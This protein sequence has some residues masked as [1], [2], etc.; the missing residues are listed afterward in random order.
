[1]VGSAGATMTLGWSGQ[2][3]TAL[4]WRP[5]ARSRPKWTARAPRRLAWRVFTARG[6]RRLALRAM[7]GGGPRG[8]GRRHG[9]PGGRH[10]FGGPPFGGGPFFAGF[11]NFPFGRGGPR[12]RRGD[13]RVAI[14]MLLAE[15]PRNGYQLMQEIESRSDGVWRPSPGSI[16]PALSQLEDEGLVLG[17]EGV[18]GSGKVFALTD[19]GRAYVA[20][21]DAD[22]P[23]P[24]DTVGDSM[25]DGL[26]D[27]RTLIG[28]VA[29][30]AMQVAH[31]G[32]EEQ[33]ARAAQTLADTRRALYRLL[34][35][36]EG[37]TQEGA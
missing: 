31:A 15:E 34:A 5:G 25:S 9:G 6:R 22:E 29:G 26:H 10:G 11:G 7:T 4:E 14:L 27:L 30:A 21:R 16:Y 2:D 24:W 3:A 35:E 12:A 33:V 13:V 20:D 36:D 28:Q 1:M 17:S 18:A 8:R 32:T 23:A 37:G 19:A